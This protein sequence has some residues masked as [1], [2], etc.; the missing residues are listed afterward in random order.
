MEET[1]RFN[2]CG[3]QIIKVFDRQREITTPT[4]QK[5]VTFHCAKSK[6]WHNNNPSMKQERPT[7]EGAKC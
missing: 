2:E 7:Y 6:Q 5:P 3:I 4:R 1:K